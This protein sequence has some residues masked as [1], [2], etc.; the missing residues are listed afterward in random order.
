[1]L[2]RGLRWLLTAQNLAPMARGEAL[3]ITTRDVADYAL[4]TRCYR[5]RGARPPPR[6][7]YGPH[8]FDLDP[9]IDMLTTNVAPTTWDDAGG[10]GSIQAMGNVLVVSQT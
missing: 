6:K 2:E 1:P 7:T 5:I 3:I 9:L 4:E 10:A 8:H